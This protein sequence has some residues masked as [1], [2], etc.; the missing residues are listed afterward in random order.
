MH[1]KAV[2]RFATNEL[3]SLRVR[4][5]CYCVNY[6]RYKNPSPS[7]PSICRLQEL[8]SR[9]SIQQLCALVWTF[10]RRRF[11]RT[12]WHKKVHECTLRTSCTIEWRLK[13]EQN[14]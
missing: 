14:I 12:P 6:G 1:I 2:L 11:V 3:S 7:R 10:A 13:A 5:S 4:K 9:R 8:Y